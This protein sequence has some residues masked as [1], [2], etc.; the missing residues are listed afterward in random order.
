MAALETL[1]RSGWACSPSPQGNGGSRGGEGWEGALIFLVRTHVSLCSISL[2]RH[3][4][5]VWQ[6]CHKATL[7]RSRVDWQPPEGILSQIGVWGGG[8]SEGRGCEMMG[9]G[10]RSARHGE[11][12]RGTVGWRSPI[13]VPAEEVVFH[14]HV[15]HAFLQR[16]L[17]LLLQGGT[18]TGVSAPHPDKQGRIQT[19]RA[20]AAEAHSIQQSCLH[21]PLPPPAP[22]F[23]AEAGR[24]PAVWRAGRKGG[25]ATSLCPSC[26]GSAL[27]PA[28]GHCQRK[29][30]HLQLAPGW[31]GAPDS[32]E[33]C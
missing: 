8:G 30:L 29:Q 16:F 22:P 5:R 31:A 6:Q 3:L 9:V 26:V 10:E 21:F 19:S 12:S 23:E 17:L 14:E 20:R 33:R 18:E 1:A 2:D 15:L 13:Y 25:A 27:P 24:G 7:R 32:E 4:P 28:P 11:G